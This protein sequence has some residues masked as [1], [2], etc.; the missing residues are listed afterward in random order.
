MNKIE[1]IQPSHIFTNY[2]FKAIPLAFDESMSYYETLCGVLDL[3]HTH[4]EVINNNADVVA[5]L[6]SYVEHYFDNLDVQEEVNNK[7][8][9]MVLDGTLG[10]IINQEIFGD[11]NGQVTQNKND[12][13]SLQTL[14]SNLPTDESNIEALQK[15]N[16]YTNQPLKYGKLNYPVEFQ[17]YNFDLIRKVDKSID[18][19]LDLT[20]YNSSNI[21]YVDRDNGNDTTGTGASDNPF[22]T[23]K[24]AFTSISSLTGT[25]YKIICKTYQFFR[26]EFI[27]ESQATMDYTLDKNVII[28]PY[29]KD[30]TILVTT[31]QDGLVWTSDG[32]NV[33]HATRSNV[34]KV[35]DMRLKD[36][37]GVFKELTKTDNLTDC[38][39]TINSFYTSGNLV[40][41][42]TTGGA[43]TTNTYLVNLPLYIAQINIINNNYLYLKNIDFYGAREIK[44]YNSSNYYNNTLICENV[45]IY[46]CND[47][48]GFSLDNIKNAYLINCKTGYNLRDGFNY[49]YT[50][51]PENDI[52]QSVNYEKNCISFNNG[53]ND[54]NTNNNCSTVHEGCNIVRVN[55]IYTNSK[56][57]AIADINTSNTLMINCKVTQE[58]GTYD[59]YYFNRLDETYSKAYLIDCSGI[60]NAQYTIDGR[61]GFVIFVKNFHGNF[62]NPNLSINLYEE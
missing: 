62:E 40:Y 33:Y 52:H 41:I 58:I 60:G 35:Y 7:L 37:Y 30:K 38:E 50:L 34:N 5:E 54:E 55:G 29:D 31:A 15:F 4:T 2:V 25:S 21:L 13:E 3:L 9:Q 23:I 18:D 61:Q 42:H 43:P 1:K 10:E 11:L 32:N 12:I 16:L 47:N 17:H 57:P 22:K 56:G 20:V 44:F 45:G 49:H 26:N 53:L 6:E 8:D 59:V 14:T 48:N 27:G 46:S 36:C 39:N 19:N 28:E 51:M 24:G